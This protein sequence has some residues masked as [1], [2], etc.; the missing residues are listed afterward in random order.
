MLQDWVARSGKYGCIVSLPVFSIIV[1]F[2]PDPESRCDLVYAS[3]TNSQLHILPMDPPNLISLESLRA[4][5]S[6]SPL[7]IWTQLPIFPDQRLQLIQAVDALS[8]VTNA[9]EWHIGGSLPSVEFSDLVNAR[10]DAQFLLLNLMPAIP[11]EQELSPRGV[12]EHVFEIARRGLR[13]FS[14]LVLFP[15]NP[16]GGTAKILSLALK[17]ALS[18]CAKAV[19]WHELPEPCKRILLWSLVLGGLQADDD[20][21]GKEQIRAWFLSQFI[22]VSSYVNVLSWELLKEWLLSVLWS[23]SVLSLA[24]WEFWN[25]CHGGTFIYQES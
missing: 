17:D 14:N 23:E 20:G 8:L 2:V 24:A 25:D 13:I 10:N 4:T 3:Q 7:V 11:D 19:R 22:E 21:E 1:C 9:L 15:M 16:T 6:S 12:G 18:C 5:V